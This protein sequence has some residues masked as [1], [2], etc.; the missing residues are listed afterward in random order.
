LILAVEDHRA[1]KGRMVTRANNP[2]SGKKQKF[3]AKNRKT[4]DAF[5][6]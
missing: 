2:L 5:L 4:P 6:P 1:Q 3:S